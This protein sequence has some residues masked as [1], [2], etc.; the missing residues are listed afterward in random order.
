MDYGERAAGKRLRA[1]LVP[2]LVALVLLAT[3]APAAAGAVSPLAAFGSVGIGA[4]QL[5]SPKGVAVDSAGR[6]YVSEFGNNRISVFNPDGSFAMAFGDSVI[7]GPPGGLEV[8]TTATTCG[9]GFPA[10]TAGGMSQPERLAFDSAGRLYVSDRVN[11]RIDVFNTSPPSFVEA[12]GWG[13]DTGKAE[14][15]VCTDASTCQGGLT[16]GGAGE[17]QVPNGLAVDAAGTLYVTDLLNRRVN[18]FATSPPSFID[19][20]GFGVDTGAEAFE[21][22]TTASGCQEGKFNGKAGALPNPVGV[23]LDGAGAL[24]VAEEN[25][26]RVDRFSVAGPPS[27]TQAFGYGVDT[28]SATTFEV[29]TTA[30]TCQQGIAGSGAGQLFN[31]QDVALDGSGAIFVDDTSNNRISQFATAGPGFTQAFGFG[32]DTGASA[33]QICTTASKCQLGL[34][35]SGTGQLSNPEGMTVDCRGGIWVADLTNNRVQRFGEPGI[36]PF[37][38]PKPEAP[39]PPGGGSPTEKCKGRPATLTGTA[40]ADRLRG[41]SRADVIF[42]GA[43]NDKV[44]GLGGNDLVCAGGGKDKVSGGAG[45]DKLNGEGGSD[46]LLGGAGKDSLN[47]GAG[48]DILIGGAGKDRLSGGAGK[49]RLSGGAGR[50]EQTQ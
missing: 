6:V 37:P 35:G 13:V 46:R 21:V 17:F 41:T 11:R 15:E 30:S 39:T 42:A 26:Q 48:A 27:F 24:F 10:G 4:G 32:V 36:A 12:F 9:E 28:G 45:N 16:G 20:F 22:C 40:A 14:F 5:T 3:Q 31:P 34:S 47:G 38:C 1:A 18:R 8:C 50:D 25:G 19:A 29:C 2:V 43:G 23:A 7:P 44:D 33:F 49:D